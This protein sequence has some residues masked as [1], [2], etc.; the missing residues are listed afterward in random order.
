MNTIQHFYRG[1]LY[2]H[3]QTQGEEPVQEVEENDSD[4]ANGYAV[5]DEGPGGVQ[6]DK[7]G[8]EDD[9]Q[10]PCKCPPQEYWK[11]TVENYTVFLVFRNGRTS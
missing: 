5:D 1:K 8:Q 2:A 9:E 6:P 11:A 4:K 3:G 7:K 10:T